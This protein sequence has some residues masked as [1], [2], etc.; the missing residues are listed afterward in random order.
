MADE[1]ASVRLA[2]VWGLY[3]LAGTESIPALTPMLSD[4]DEGVR[5][6][7][8][9]CIGWVG[10]QIANAGNHH[11]QKVISALIQCLNDPAESI[12][13]AALDALQAV[14]GKKICEA[15]PEGQISHQ[16]LID[17]WRSWWKEELI[18]S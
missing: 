7:A 11:C 18:C 3:R 8:I 12:K 10:G 5:R 1:V 16:F 13:N 15:V 4:N 17:Q 9:T 14:T 6:R 2:A